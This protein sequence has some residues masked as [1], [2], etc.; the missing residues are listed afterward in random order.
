MQSTR[1]HQGINPDT[2]DEIREDIGATR[3]SM[4]EKLE[5]LEKRVQET[6]G[7]V[8]ETVKDIV[9]NVMGT[10]D[11]TVDKVK[12]SVDDTIDKIKGS[13]DDTIEGAKR[14]YDLTAQMAQHPWMML[15]GAMLIGYLLGRGGRK[16]APT[17]PIAAV[18][19][20]GARPVRAL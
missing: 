4:T 10:V 17:R 5:M 11:D 19:T 20:D 3:A 9:E 7:G 15:G 12:G 1:Q 8:E 6:V 18:S 16:A 14:T 13:V 2:E